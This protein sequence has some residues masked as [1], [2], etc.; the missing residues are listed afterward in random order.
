M[1]PPKED[2]MASARQGT[3]VIFPFIRYDDAAAALD[4]LERAFGFERGLVAPGAEGRIE[5]AELWLG[6]SA[7]LIGSSKRDDFAMR[8]ARDLGGVNQGLYIVVGDVD[9]HCTR[10]T[11]AGANI[12]RPL[13]DQDY[14][15]R[16]YTAHDPEGNLWSFGTYRPGTYEPG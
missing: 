10:A 1:A 14:G 7:V 13:V 5:H 8:S 9:A 11:A 3:P 6:A 16:E 4:W 2:A 12:V 15:S